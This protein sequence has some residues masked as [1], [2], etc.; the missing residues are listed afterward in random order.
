MA[1]PRVEEVLEHIWTYE[2]E[3]G[4]RA[5]K[6]LLSQWINPQSVDAVLQDMLKDKFVHMYNSL[7]V[8]TATG[9][10]EAELIVRRHRLAERLLKDVLELH[11]DA[12]DSSACQF[13]HILSEEVTTSICTLLGHPTRCPHGKV[14]PP[15]ECCQ[16]AKKV[17]SPLVL[18]LFE[19]TSGEQAKVV[20]I[21]TKHH[22]RLDRLSSL[23]LLPGTTIRVHQKQ[24][25]IVLQMGE[26]Q[27]ALDE[28]IARDIYVRRLR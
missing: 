18:P 15:G 9:R 25:T 8:L 26:T 22:P 5:S 3:F 23:G 24:P 12:M 20:Y 6:D 10:K 17:V 28:D 1:E 7:I 27:V 21:T 11:H 14:I 4:E 13:E 19:L 16:R 2:E